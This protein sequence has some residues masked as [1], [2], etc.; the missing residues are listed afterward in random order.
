MSNAMDSKS[1][2]ILHPREMLEKQLDS[3]TDSLYSKNVSN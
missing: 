2:D 3:A 1:E